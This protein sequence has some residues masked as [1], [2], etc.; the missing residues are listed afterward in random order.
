MDKKR[1]ERPSV[2]GVSIRSSNGA[3]SRKGSVVNGGEDLTLAAGG[4][5]ARRQENR[6]VHS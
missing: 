3:A 2:G 6:E 5:R 4:G 1:N